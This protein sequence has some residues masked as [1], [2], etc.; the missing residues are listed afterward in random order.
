MKQCPRCDSNNTV[1]VV[2][3]AMILAIPEL[4]REVKEGRAEVCTAC[5]GTQSEYIPDDFEPGLDP[6][7]REALNEEELLD[8]WVLAH[9]GNPYDFGDRVDAFTDPFG[10]HDDFGGGDGGFDGFGNWGGFGGGEE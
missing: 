8:D 7:D 4:R 2:T 5:C 1:R 9:G 3:S 10:F 6:Y